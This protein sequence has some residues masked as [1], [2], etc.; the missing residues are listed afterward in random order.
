MPPSWQMLTPAAQT[1]NASG[2]VRSGGRLDPETEVC[3]RLCHA[4]V[5]GDER[6]EVVSDDLGGGKVDGIETSNL[7]S[8]D[9]GRRAVEKLAAQGNLIA[10]AKMPPSMSHGR[11]SAGK[12]R[13]YH[14]DSVEG[15]RHEP[16]PAVS[17]EETP[18]G[19]GLSFPL[20]EL[21]QSRRIEVQAH[22]ASSR[23]AAKRA[24][25]SIP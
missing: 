18:E 17:A 15:T 19:V 14:F 16:L 1:V 22:R 7:K 8:R 13:P 6:P 21:H 11:G 2:S 9:Q 25:A 20:D 5:V 23:I 24:D 10:A 3:R 12:D 4:A